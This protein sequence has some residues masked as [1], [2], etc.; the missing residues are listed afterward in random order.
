MPHQGNSVNIEGGLI[1]T[2]SSLK[3]KFNP[4]YGHMFIAS[5]CLFFFF[6]RVVLI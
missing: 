1:T 5:V 6:Y 3:K 2:P 4:N